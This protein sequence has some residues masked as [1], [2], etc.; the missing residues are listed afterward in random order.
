MPVKVERRAGRSAKSPR[1]VTVVPAGRGAGSSRSTRP[2]RR[3]NRQPAPVPV[4]E[5]R[6]SSATPAMLGSASPRKP[7]VRT[8]PRPSAGYLLVAWRWQAS[9]R[10]AARM[11][12]P[13]SPTRMRSRPPP[14]TSMR[15][16]VAPASS[17]FSTSSLTTDAGRSIVSP[18]AIPAATPTGSTRMPP[19]GGRRSVAAGDTTSPPIGG[20]GPRRCVSMWVASVSTGQ[21]QGLAG[22][23]V[24]DRSRKS[25]TGAH[26]R[27]MTFAPI[28]GER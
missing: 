22:V 2:P 4:A 25:Q 15:T 13:S 7:R 28:A 3:V 18:A 10:S 1:T 16:V 8:A 12:R 21:I 5:T 17:A 19:A 11:P 6:S 14:R 23:G 26:P 9:Q 24:A 20:A 27:E